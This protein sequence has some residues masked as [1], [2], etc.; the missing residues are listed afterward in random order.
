MLRAMY[1]RHTTDFKW[2]QGSIDRLAGTDKLRAA[3]EA[4]TVDALIR[5]WDADAVRFG[6]MEQ[7]YLIYK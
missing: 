2:R 6:A 1:A 7:P 3:V 5:V 4:G